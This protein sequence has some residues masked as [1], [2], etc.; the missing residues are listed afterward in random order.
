MKFQRTTLDN[1]LEIVVEQ[2]ES[3]LSTALG[4]FVRTGSRDET[5]EIAGVSHFLEH[6]VFKGTERRTAADVNRELDELGGISNACTSEESTAFYAKTLPELQERAIELLSDILRPALRKEDFDTE[7]QV[8][9][10]EI[11]MYEDQPP[12]LIDDDARSH[13]FAGR[14]L[15]RSVLGSRESVGGLT[16]EAMREY[17][18]RRYSPGNVVFVASGLVD[19]DKTVRCVESCCG[20]WKPFETSRQI[21]RG[22]GSSGVLVK[23]REETSQEYVLQLMDAPAAS[24]SD[25]IA[26]GILATVIGGTGGR[27]FWELVDSGR[28]DVA[29]LA[30]LF[31]SD[32]G[33]FEFYLA[34]DPEDADDNLA[35]ARRILDE[36]VR[37][38]AKEEETERAKTMVLTR[39]AL[40]G[41]SP[42]RRLFSIGEEWLSEGRYKSVAEQLE[43]ARKTTLDDANAVAKKYPFDNSFTVAIGELD[44]LRDF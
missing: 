34:C 5:D 28:A 25:R 32:A 1:G 41:E 3:A 30:P 19:F 36:I 40:L 20:H 27:M 38:G 6:M 14:P 29:A 26:A 24:D 15:S 2:N 23:K 21:S 4:F 9:L 44:S 37:D 43:E 33:C 35:I 16:P 17:F 8:V 12:F 10:E 39:I 18:E 7:K 11:K 31:Y 22:R 13:F 42:M